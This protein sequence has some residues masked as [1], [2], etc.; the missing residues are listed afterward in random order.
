YP[1]G[2]TFALN[3]YDVFRNEITVKGSFAQIHDFGRALAYLESGA[4]RA[5]EIVT[6]E[7]PLA[8]WNRALE[9]AW[10]RRG[11]KTVML[12]SG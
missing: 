6:D 4:V 11:I 10:G 7:F 12:P 1:E 9:H 8:D 5:G 2:A 3:P